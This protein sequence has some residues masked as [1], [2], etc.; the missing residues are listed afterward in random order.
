MGIYTTTDFAAGKLY[1][2]SSPI[3][4][5]SKIIGTITRENGEMG[6]LLLLKNGKQVQFNAGVIRRLP[7]DVGRHPK[8]DET[9]KTISA[10]LPLSMYDKV[11]KP[12]QNWLFGVI[13]TN[14]PI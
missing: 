10:R 4:A 14:L 9:T 6:A 3:P 1:T 5:G 7:G 8:F 11:P 2:G 13:K 12:H